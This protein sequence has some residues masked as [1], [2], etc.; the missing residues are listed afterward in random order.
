MHDALKSYRVERAVQQMGAIAAER[1]MR[2]MAAEAE[3]KT[4]TDAPS[5][6]QVGAG[7]HFSG[8]GAEN[9]VF[10]KVSTRDC[11]TF[12]SYKRNSTQS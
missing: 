8:Y 5:Y 4:A 2:C 9:G 10:M 12:Y 3:A 1:A 11:A 6:T 7:Q